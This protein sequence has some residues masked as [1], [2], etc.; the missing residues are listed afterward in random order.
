MSNA[1]A[2][3]L[4]RIASLTGAWRY[5]TGEKCKRLRRAWRYGCGALSAD[6]AQS[7]F[8]D[9]CRPAGWYP[10]LLLMVEDPLEQV[11]EVFADHPELPRLVADGCAR[12]DAKWQN[13]GDE[14]Y[15]ARRW[16]IDVAASYAADRGI[17]L[18]PIEDETPA[19]APQ[20]EP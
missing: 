6:D 15:D 20:S 3:L 11:R 16:A 5:R 8:L 7:I 19:E 1:A 17:T 13:F 9:C 14:L 4:P 10:L 18:V 2:T 12:V